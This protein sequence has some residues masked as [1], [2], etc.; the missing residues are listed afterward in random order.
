MMIENT[1][2]VKASPGSLIC[3]LSF[4]RW[5]LRVNCKEIIKV[6]KATIR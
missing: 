3:V 6:K 5:T 4:A 1:K 2:Q